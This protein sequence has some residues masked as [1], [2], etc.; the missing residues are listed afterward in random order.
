M[1]V[2]SIADLL[3]LS[4]KDLGL[5]NEELSVISNISLEEIMGNSYHSSCDAINKWNEV[6]NKQEGATSIDD[7]Q[8]KQT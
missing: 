6:N 4:G 2:K 8:L 3:A 5:T 7:N 1:N